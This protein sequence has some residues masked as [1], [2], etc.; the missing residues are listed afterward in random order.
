MMHK[1]HSMRNPKSWH[2]DAH[3][4]TGK[5]YVAPLIVEQNTLTRTKHQQKAKQYFLDAVKLLLEELINGAAVF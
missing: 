2:M 5:L 4:L 3:N 1:M